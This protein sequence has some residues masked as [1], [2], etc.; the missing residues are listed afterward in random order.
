MKTRFLGPQAALIT[1]QAEPR[2]WMIVTL[3]YSSVEGPAGW[4]LGLIGLK[5][6]VWTV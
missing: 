1:V 3:A 2:V 4:S 5:P 6:T